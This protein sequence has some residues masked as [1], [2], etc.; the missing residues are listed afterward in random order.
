VSTRLLLNLPPKLVQTKAAKSPAADVV[1]ETSIKSPLRPPK[2]IQTI[3]SNG[4]YLSL[5]S[6]ALRAP[7]SFGGLRGSLIRVGHGVSMDA[8][9]YGGSCDIIGGDV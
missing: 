6:K 1:I 9:V 7:F 5:V 2:L 8:P 3:K 4:Q